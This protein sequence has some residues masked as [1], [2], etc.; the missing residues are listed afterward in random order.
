[1]DAVVKFSEPSGHLVSD[2]FQK[3]PSK[4]QYPDYYAIVKGPIDLKII[5]Q[6]IQMSLY[7]SV[8]AMAKDIDLLAKNAKTYNEPG[9]QVFKDSNTI[10][11]FFS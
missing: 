8:S 1:M 9:S 3:L 5:A 6:K 10:R 11:I 2:L 7:R 4:V